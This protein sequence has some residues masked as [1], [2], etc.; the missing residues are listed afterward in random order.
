MNQPQDHAGEE[1]AKPAEPGNDEAPETPRSLS[2]W[3]LITTT[4]W[5]VLGVQSRRNRERDFTHGKAI[6]FIVAGIVFTLVFVIGMILL[7]NLVLSRAG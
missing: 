4:L 7:V 3:E 5:A 2:L 1:G 6:H